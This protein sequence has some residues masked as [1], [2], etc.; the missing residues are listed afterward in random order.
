MYEHPAD[1]TGSV[2]EKSYTYK[3]D[4]VS[5]ERGESHKLYLGGSNPPTATNLEV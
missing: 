5:Q 3:I 4:A 1:K 2:S